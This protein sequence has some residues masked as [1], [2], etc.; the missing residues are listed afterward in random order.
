MRETMLKRVV[1]IFLVMLLLSTQGCLAPDA[2]ELELDADGDGLLATT[3]SDDD[4]DGVADSSDAFPLNSS[5]TVDTDGDGVG[6]NG[7]FAPTDP[8]ISRK[9]SFPLNDTG[10]TWGG[11]YSSGNNISCIGEEI[12]AQDCS[13]GRD[14]NS[15]TNNDSDGHAGFSFTKIDGSGNA[16]PA[17]A[18]SWDCVQDN[19]TGLMWEVKTTDG[20]LRDTNW[21]Y[22]WYNSDATTNGGSTGAAN[23]GNCLDSSNCDTEKYVAQVNSAGLCGYSDWH[24][25]KKETLRSILSYDR[26]NPAIDTDWFP[27]TKSSIY[28]SSSPGA[29]YSSHAWNVDFNYGNHYGNRNYNYYVRLVRTG[30]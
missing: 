21:S 1:Q 12:S 14:A 25:P 9:Y 28:W 26:I 23:G 27:N 3:D 15:S 10:L 17:S 11:N 19:V 30:Q 16:L 5:E 4:G 24:L 22:T 13:H 29:G 2:E 8:N 7:D 20:G 18:T 6:D